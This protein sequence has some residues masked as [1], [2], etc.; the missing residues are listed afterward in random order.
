MNSSYEEFISIYLLWERSK[1]VLLFMYL[2]FNP[3]LN[4]FL[5]YLQFWFKPEAAAAVAAAVAAV[6]AAAAAAAGAAYFF[7][8]S[9]SFEL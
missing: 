4:F 8:F 1:A 3:H 9:S 2:L 5:Y 6:A 7:R